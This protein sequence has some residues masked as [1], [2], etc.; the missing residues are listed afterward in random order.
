M[1]RPAFPLNN[2]RIR[3]YENSRTRY[4]RLPLGVV[5]AH[6]FMVRNTGKAMEDRADRKV[7][8]M[9]RLASTL[10]RYAQGASLSNY[11]EAMTRAA[12]DL[13]EHAA[14]ISGGTTN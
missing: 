12:L 2:I 9:R 14:R 1:H 3:R 10:R 4:F 8:D 5:T 6:R 13:E 7:G 11:A